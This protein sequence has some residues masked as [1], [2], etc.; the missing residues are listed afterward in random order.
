[1]RKKPAP[2]RLWPRS[3]WSAGTAACSAMKNTVANM[4][5]PENRPGRRLR[6]P[7][8][9]VR[10]AAGAGAPGAA[11]T[12]ASSRIR[13]RR[14]R[15]SWTFSRR[16][17]F[18]FSFSI[19]AFLSILAWARLSCRF[20]ARSI[21][22]APPRFLT[23]A[24][25]PSALPPGTVLASPALMNDALLAAVAAAHGT[26]TYVYDLDTVTDRFRRVERAFP[27]ARVH[28]AVKANALGPLLAHLAAL[29]AHAEALTLGELE[30]AL[31]AGFAPEHVVLGGPGHTPDLARRAA[32]V[33]VGLVSLDSVGAWEVWRE[34]AAPATRFL[35]R[36]NPGFDPRT[37]EH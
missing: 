4:K 24:P 35:V 37:H 18:R 34:V 2:M 29:G 8:V 20:M 31:R 9:Y 26:P 11:R 21:T 17:C 10:R 27:G 1:M 19:S 12:L 14:S 28:Y 36:L 15:A 22:G 23:A 6:S 13:L 32:E 7:G 5:A 33:G 30:R 3:F 25:P 16:A